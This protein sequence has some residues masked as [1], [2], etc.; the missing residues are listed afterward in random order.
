MRIF[1]ISG[2]CPDYEDGNA[3]IVH[4]VYATREQAEAAFSE[5]IGHTKDHAEVAERIKGICNGNGCWTESVEE[6]HGS[7]FSIKSYS[8]SVS[9][10]LANE[11]GLALF[12]KL[13]PIGLIDGN[14]SIDLKDGINVTH[15]YSAMPFKIA[16]LHLSAKEL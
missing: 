5:L 8:C 11:E 2:Y 7:E 10:D 1:C 15:L 14:S 16:S 12:R 6:T 13:S 9:I 4:E 3:R